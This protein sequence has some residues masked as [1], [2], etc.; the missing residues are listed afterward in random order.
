MTAHVSGRS[1]C[2]AFGIVATLM[3]SMTACVASEAGT[4]QRPTATPSEEPRPTAIQPV[5][6]LAVSPSEACTAALGTIPNDMD[7]MLVNARFELAAQTCASADDYAST[8]YAYPN[9]L[10]FSDLTD[11]DI[12]IVLRTVCAKVRASSMEST[13]VCEDPRTE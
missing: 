5:S 11:A 3:V 10:G 7:D 4:D 1:L 13:P 8:L 6:F 9:A 2:L 12:A